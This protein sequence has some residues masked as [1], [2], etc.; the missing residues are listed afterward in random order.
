MMIEYECATCGK[1]V[2]KH[3]SETMNNRFCSR[4]CKSEWQR[5]QKPVSRDWLYQKYIVEELDCVQIAKI[6][7]RDPKSVWSWLRDLDIPTRGRGK[8]GNHKYVKTPAFKG[9]HHSDEVRERLRQARLL[10]G[11]VP[12]LK[13]GVHHLK[14]KKGADTPNWRGGV[15]PQRQSFYASPEWKEAVKAIW[16]RDDA[17]CQ[18]CGLRHNEVKDRTVRFHI[19][20]I[21]SFQVKRLRAEPS[22]LVL[23]CMPC[24]LW[25][26]SS[27]N[28][29]REFINDSDGK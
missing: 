8:T 18:R 26:H 25:V 4:A 13:N 27:E 20:H 5:Q 9:K 24:H 12:Y 17:T 21:V 29:E 15:T 23:L 28:T 16:H 14:G 19:H 1:H 7:S 6:V 22:N 11:H 10:D 2:R 3:K